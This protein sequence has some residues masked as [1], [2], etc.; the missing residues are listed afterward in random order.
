MVRL[1]VL[2][3]F[4]F[5]CAANA[6]QAK[7][8]LQAQEQQLFL[9][10]QKIEQQNQRIDGLVSII[11]GLAQQLNASKN[12]D[13]TNNQNE[14]IKELA[15]MI[16]K[17]NENYVTKEDLAKALG[18]SKVDVSKPDV[19]QIDKDL[20]DKS[21]QEL[22]Q[23]AVLLYR[24]GEYDQAKEKFEAVEKKGFQVAATNYY[25][26]E[27]AYYTKKYEDAIF[28]FKKSVGLDDKASYMDTLLLHTGIALENTKDNAQAKKFYENIIANY[29][30]KPSASIAKKRLEGLN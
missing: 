9:L 20:V 26:G 13:S 25:L 3:L 24:S 22:Y 17:I 23:A 16:D 12:E 11:E 6:S 10:E 27:V 18:S 1:G 19:K 14:L 21:P 28:Y 15:S 2:C 8:K 5:F 7:A 29:S 4:A 30:S